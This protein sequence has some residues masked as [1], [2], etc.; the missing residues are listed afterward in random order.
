MEKKKIEFRYFSCVQ[1]SV[2]QRFGTGSYIGVSKEPGKTDWVWDEEKVVPIPKDECL[3]YHREYQNALRNKSISERTEEEYKK[4]LA[5]EEKQ[6]KE[7]QK[8]IAKERAEAE[9]SAARASQEQDPSL[10][11]KKENDSEKGGSE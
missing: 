10:E 1:G 4:Y 7:L 6:A 5:R 9:K 11:N 3:R 2:V 8:K